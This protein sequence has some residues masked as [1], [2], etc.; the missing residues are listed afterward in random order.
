MTKK[1][2]WTIGNSIINHAEVIEADFMGQECVIDLF[3]QLTEYLPH[4][5]EDIC[6]WAL[7]LSNPDEL[8]IWVETA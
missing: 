3:C 7:I 2:E 4:W 1:W 8:G 6:I 5:T